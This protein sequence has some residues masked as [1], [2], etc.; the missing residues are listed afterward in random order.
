MKFKVFT[1]QILFLLSIIGC[2]V[3]A[4]IYS[5]VDESIDFNKFKTFAWLPDKTDSTQRPY[6]NEIIRNNIRNYFG[7]SFASIG[8]TF[9]QDTPDVLLQLIVSVKDKEKVVVYAIYPPPYYYRRYYYGSI[10][11]S[12]YP[13][14][15]YYRKGGYYQSPGYYAEKYNYVESSITLNVLDRKLNKLIWTGTAI[16]N[17]YD[18]SYINRDIHPA[19]EAIMRKFPHTKRN[20][21]D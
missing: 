17:I 9:N 14:Y 13:H 19:V 2:S 8:Y 1:V 6:N 4:E 3:Y 20:V 12:P 11:Y 16:G 15:Y 5:N 21:S 7:S 10:Y 18:P